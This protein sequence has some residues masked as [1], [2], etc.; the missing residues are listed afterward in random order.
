MTL[1]KSEA[2]LLEQGQVDALSMINKSKFPVVDSK[3]F[4]RERKG[5]SS[6]RKWDE[7]RF[8]FGLDFPK[9]YLSPLGS[10]FAI[11]D[12]EMEI[13]AEKNNQR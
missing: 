9:Y 12:A 10:A 13:E 1:H 5:G 7:Y 3:S 2:I 8:H 11:S 6:E 4:E